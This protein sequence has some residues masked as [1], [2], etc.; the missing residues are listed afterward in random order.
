MEII[1]NHQISQETAKTGK[2]ANKK[3]IMVNEWNEFPILEMGFSAGELEAMEIFFKNMPEQSGMAFFD[4]QHRDHNYVGVLPDILQRTIAATVIELNGQLEVKPNYVYVI[5]PNKNFS[6]VKG[7]LH[8]FNP[9]ASRGLRLPIDMFFP[10]LTI[11]KLNKAIEII[12]SGISSD[13]SLGIKA[14]KENNG[15]V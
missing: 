9:V 6:I 15:L 4:V 8:L 3:F 7:F 12:L 10:S 2:T 11:D 1:E 14:V 13:G 5:S